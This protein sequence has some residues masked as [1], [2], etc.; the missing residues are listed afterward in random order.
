[1][2]VRLVPDSWRN[3]H[4]A[5]LLAAGRSATLGLL[6]AAAGLLVIGLAPPRWAGWSTAGGMFIYGAS[7][8]LWQVG[9]VTLRQYVTPRDLLGR[10]TATMRV[11]STFPV[12]VAAIVGG[13][14][15]EI[16]G[17]RPT[18]VAAGLG[19]AVAAAAIFTSK[20][21]HFKDDHEQRHMAA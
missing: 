14:L 2:P 16:L 11:I 13:I 5:R 8:V 21:P 19:A 10:V 4:L 17:A 18:L 9:S 20:V 3:P 15:G 6:G 12:P 1:M 7:A